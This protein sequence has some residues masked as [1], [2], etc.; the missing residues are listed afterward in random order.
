MR[1]NR[2]VALSL[3][4]IVSNTVRQP[5]RPSGCLSNVPTLFAGDRVC[6]WALAT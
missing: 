6:P 5:L 1:S 4:D 3:H 2:L